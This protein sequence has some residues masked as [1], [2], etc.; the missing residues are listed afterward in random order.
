[1]HTM[2]SEKKSL[3]LSSNF[4]LPLTTSEQLQELEN[5]IENAADLQDLI[6]VLSHVGGDTIKKNVHFIMKKLMDGELSLHYSAK[7]KKQKKDFSKLSV[8]NAVLGMLT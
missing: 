5:K 1:M 7:G 8:Y 3:K 4:N 6:N 2:L